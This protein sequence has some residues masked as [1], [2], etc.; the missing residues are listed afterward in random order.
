M[1]LEAAALRERLCNAPS[2]HGKMFPWLWGDFLG[3][4][5]FLH[6][7]LCIPLFFQFP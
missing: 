4:G 3:L 2:S 6:T 5:G 7:E 1:S